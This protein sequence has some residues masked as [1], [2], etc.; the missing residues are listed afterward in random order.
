LAAFW[1]AFE[2]SLSFPQVRDAIESIAAARV[3]RQLFT[4]QASARQSLDARVRELVN[5]VT[6]QLSFVFNREDGEMRSDVLF[7][8]FVATL[9]PYE[10]NKQ[11]MSQLIQPDVFK[12]E[13]RKHF[14]G[15]LA[16][17]DVD[18]MVLELPEFSM[19][20]LQFVADNAPAAAD[21]NPDNTAAHRNKAIWNFWRR[22]DAGN[23]CPHL[24][25]LAQLVLSIVPSSAAAER[26]FSLL[27]AFFE[28]QQLVGEARGALED[29]IEQMIAMSF[30]KSNKKNPFHA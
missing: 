11:E 10:H 22:L 3:A 8:T 20:C 6:Q 25:R 12:A 30:E 21:D 2:P 13:V 1:R 19:Q 5:P 14:P 24:R 29:Y 17:A 7:Y 9:N 4:D 28:S 18:R 26:C 16:P 27:K 15:R 23:L